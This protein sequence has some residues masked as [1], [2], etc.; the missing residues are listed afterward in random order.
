MNNNGNNI[1]NSNNTYMS[2]NS[3]GNGTGGGNGT[4]NG[5]TR[6]CTPQQKRGCFTL[7]G[8][9]PYVLTADWV[10]GNWLCPY[11]LRVPAGAPVMK[12]RCP[13]CQTLQ[14]PYGTINNGVEWTWSGD[15]RTY[16]QQ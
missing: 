12:N 1:Y 8:S 10:K 3:S 11:L 16:G 14:R 5:M 4:G 6:G 2:Y 9:Q 13:H 15:S 7:E